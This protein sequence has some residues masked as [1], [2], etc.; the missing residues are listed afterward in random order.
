[1]PDKYS[2]TR[3]GLKLG[4]LVQVIRVAKSGHKPRTLILLP[5]R[6]RDIRIPLFIMRSPIDPK[7]SAALLK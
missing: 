1:M 5:K 7:N 4:S 3:S 2:L 6:S